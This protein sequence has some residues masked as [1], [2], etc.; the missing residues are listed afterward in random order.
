MIRDHANRLLLMTVVSSFVG[1]IFDLAM[2]TV[3]AITPLSAPAVFWGTVASYLYFIS[4]LISLVFLQYLCFL[5]DPDGIQD[6]S[7]QDTCADLAAL[8]GH[9]GD[10][11]AEPVHP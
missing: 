9:A 10:A 5:R 8:P 11:G 2:E 3:T 7:F 1:V 6:P 4:R